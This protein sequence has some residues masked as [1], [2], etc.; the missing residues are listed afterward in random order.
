MLLEEFDTNKIAVINPKDIYKIKQ[1][2]PT[3]LVSIFSYVLFDQIVSF[4]E[5]KQ[6]EQYSDVDGFWSIYEAEYKG[7]RFALMKARVIIML[8][9]RIRLMSIIITESFSNRSL[10]SMAILM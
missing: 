1:D 10:R 2:F 9:H 3:T 8:L 5:A 4:L 6:I 7:V